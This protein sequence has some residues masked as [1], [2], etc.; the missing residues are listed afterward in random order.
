MI[1][2]F[3]MWLLHRKYIKY[4]KPIF[5]IKGTDK[6]YPKYL[7]YTEDCRQYARMDGF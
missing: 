1:T 4:G 2:R 3:V 7:L 5:Y 6:D